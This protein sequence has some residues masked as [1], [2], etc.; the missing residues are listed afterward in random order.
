MKPTPT[1]LFVSLFRLVLT[2]S[3]CGQSTRTSSSID[4]ASGGGR[5]CIDFQSGFDDRQAAEYCAAQGGTA[6]AT[7]CS[8]GVGRCVTAQ[9]GLM[10][11]T[12]YY[13]A[14]LVSVARRVCTM[15]G[16][17]FETP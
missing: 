3:G 17:T 13:D 1:L 15:V 16:G 6:A 4:D 10:F 14:A 12:H 9:D 5:T 11:T 2:L 8:T 7:A